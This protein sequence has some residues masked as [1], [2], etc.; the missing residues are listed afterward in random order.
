MASIEKFGTEASLSSGPRSVEP[1]GT[2]SGTIETFGA[3]APFSA[4]PAS[5]K[6]ST[7][8]GTIEKFGSAAP[9][10]QNASKGYQSANTPMSKRSLVQGK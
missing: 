5:A 8:S 7:G 3:K 1:N 4:S 10:K 6:P 2:K 9:L